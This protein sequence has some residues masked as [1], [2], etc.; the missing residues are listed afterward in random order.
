MISLGTRATWCRYRRQLAY[1]GGRD[2]QVE[3][4]PNPR[5]T[6]AGSISRAHTLYCTRYLAR[7]QALVGIVNI[8]R[9]RIKLDR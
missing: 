9:G 3:T 8:F 5:S 2:K 4:N 1:F 7:S 6:N